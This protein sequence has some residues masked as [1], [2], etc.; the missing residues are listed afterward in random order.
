LEEK[1]ERFLTDIASG[2]AKRSRKLLVLVTLK[3]NYSNLSGIARSVLF[4][5]DIF[6]K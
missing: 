4:L 2:G 3:K 6:K 1:G 5:S